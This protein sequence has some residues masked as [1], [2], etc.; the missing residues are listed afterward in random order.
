MS[1]VTAG[2]N[3][4]DFL[5]VCAIFLAGRSGYHLGFAESVWTTLRWGLILGLGTLAWPVLGQEIGT[6]TGWS[7][8][9]SALLAYVSV[10]T[11]TWIVVDRLQRIFA[12]RLLLAIPA[13][14]VDGVFGSVA[15]VVAAGA[16]ALVFLVLFS[17]F[18]AAPI[19]WNP[20]HL[21]TEDSIAEFA[22]AIFTT[23]RHTVYDESFLGRAVQEHLRVFI[24]QPAA[25]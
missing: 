22:R 24:I 7:F 19:D 10:G 21:R 18:E 4:V 16:G 23:V 13:G 8:T 25:A 5:A 11:V 1:E 20:M 3:I 15:G 9:T 12:A 6:H 17:P 14:P 2:A